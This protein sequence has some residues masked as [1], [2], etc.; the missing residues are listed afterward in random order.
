MLIPPRLF[1]DAKAWGRVIGHSFTPHE[2]P[3]LLETIFSSQVGK[4]K[5]RSIHGDDAQD[6]VDVIDQARFV[7]A[8]NWIL[9]HQNQH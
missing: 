8:D 6:F 3:S 4:E 1:C 2:L 9:V 5:I 7:S